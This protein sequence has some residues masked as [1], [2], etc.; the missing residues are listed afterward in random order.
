M[1][2][3]NKNGKTQWKSSKSINSDFLDKPD[4]PTLINLTNRFESLRVG[5]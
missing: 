4:T 1:L 2:T 5:E 3:S